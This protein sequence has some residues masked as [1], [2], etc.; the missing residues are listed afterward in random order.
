MALSTEVTFAAILDF[1]GLFKLVKFIDL[2]WASFYEFFSLF[3][4]ESVLAINLVFIDGDLWLLMHD[5]GSNRGP[6][7][8]LLTISFLCLELEFELLFG[9][10]L[11][12]DNRVLRL[13]SF[14]I[15][16][17]NRLN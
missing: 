17:L 9:T 15:D 14:V 2:S 13:P 5:A 16:K 11:H 7:C 8:M 10:Q 6:L 1:Y 12:N 4:G 3:N